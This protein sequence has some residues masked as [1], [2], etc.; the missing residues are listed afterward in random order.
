[1]IQE[2]YQVGKF[3]EKTKIMSFLNLLNLKG[4]YG[5]LI[6]NLELKIKKNVFLGI[7]LLGGNKLAI[8]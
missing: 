4:D 6:G 5:G 2:F 8:I 3:F 7:P 1:M